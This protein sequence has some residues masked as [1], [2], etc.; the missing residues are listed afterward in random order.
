MYCQACL[1]AT[2]NQHLR[3][4]DA[5]SVLLSHNLLHQDTSLCTR[6]SAAACFARSFS[7][8]LLLVVSGARK[9]SAKYCT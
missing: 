1:R 8:T 6:W 3:D 5:S 7:T 9:L 4:S 2:A